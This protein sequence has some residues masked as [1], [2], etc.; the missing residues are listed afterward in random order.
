MYHV[1]GVIDPT[2]SKFRDSADQRRQSKTNV[3]PKDATNIEKHGQAW[4]F[5]FLLDV[6][7]GGGSNVEFFGS[8]FL[9]KIQFLSSFLN[10]IRK[11][12]KIGLNVPPIF[13]RKLI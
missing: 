11:P 5:T 7:Q 2:D 4:I 6:L 1:E 10:P 8:F 12:I 13:G 9:R 3:D